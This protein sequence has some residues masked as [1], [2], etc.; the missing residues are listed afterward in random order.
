[1]VFHGGFDCFRCSWHLASKACAHIH[2]Q[3][4]FLENIDL[5]WPAVVIAAWWARSAEWVKASVLQRWKFCWK[6]GV[7]QRSHHWD[8]GIEISSIWWGK[9]CMLAMLHYEKW[10]VERIHHQCYS[11]K[12]S[13]KN[14]VCLAAGEEVRSKQHCPSANHLSCVSE[15]RDAISS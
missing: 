13:K 8:L 7:W 5:R 6:S 10:E 2:H 4:C 12:R 15:I 11:W 1:M 14:N 3:L 9:M